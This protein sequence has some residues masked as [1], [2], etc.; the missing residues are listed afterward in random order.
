MNLL[1]SAL[2]VARNGLNFLDKVVSIC[3]EL[4]I[5]P[6][7]L[8]AVMKQESGINPQ[9]VNKQLG[10]SDNAYSRAASRATGLIQF[11]PKTAKGLG[12]TTQALYLL[13][14][15]EQLDY[16][17]KYFLP[18]KG[19]IKSP[20]DLYIIV[21]YPAALGQP[22][23]YKIGGSVTAQQNPAFDLDKNKQIT[24]GEFRQYI[25]RK[26]FAD[27]FALDTKKKF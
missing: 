1:Y 21:F 26:T 19:R 2:A 11:M 25:R 7:W 22:D 17:R 14:G 23:S 4:G 5:D 15:V 16:V 20:E 24:L 8:M 10:D 6:N 12:T 27:L 13:N 9:A 18:Y 3:Q